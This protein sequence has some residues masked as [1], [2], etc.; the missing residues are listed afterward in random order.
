MTSSKPVVLV[1]EDDQTNMDLVEQV[2]ED[3]YSIL[4]AY[5]GRT[6]LGIAGSDLPDAVLLDIALPEMN[7]LEVARHL[8]AD[9]KTAR[10]PIIALTAS[11]M[12]GDEESARAAGCDGFIGKPFDEDELLAVLADLIGR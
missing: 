9:P 10:I 5:N 11:V 4:K 7:G 2:L 3:T 1:V 8:K 6:G 12:P